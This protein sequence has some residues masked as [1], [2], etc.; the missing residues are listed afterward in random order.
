MQYKIFQY[1][2]PCDSEPAELN[3][4][5]ANKGHKKRAGEVASGM[6]V[7]PIFENDKDCG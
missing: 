4:Y 3:R 7:R 2:L 5:L 6:V 1:T